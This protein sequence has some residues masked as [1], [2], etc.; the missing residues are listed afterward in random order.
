MPHSPADRSFER[1]AD[2]DLAR[3]AELAARDRSDRFRRK[4]R[5][6]AYADRVLCVALCQGA[7]LH[8]L[9]G[10]TGIKDIDVWTFYAEHAVGPFP[11]RWLTHADF[12]PSRFG[13]HPEDPPTF[14]GRRIDLIGRSLP[15]EPDADPS[16]ALVA[17]LSAGRTGSAQALARKAVVLLDPE[18]LR[19]QVVWPPS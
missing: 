18:P 13:R 10:R 3:L 6:S 4:P 8:F 5:W 2:E 17:D 11:P 12:G 19:G 15:D 16:S 1:F 7:A 9:N 14:I